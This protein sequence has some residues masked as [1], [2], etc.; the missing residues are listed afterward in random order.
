LPGIKTLPRMH[1]FWFDVD[2][3]IQTIP[4][5]S[6]KRM[7]TPL[8]P[9]NFQTRLANATTM[10]ES[11]TSPNAQW[12]HSQIML[13]TSRYLEVQQKENHMDPSQQACYQSESKQAAETRNHT[14][15]SGCGFRFLWAAVAQIRLLNECLGSV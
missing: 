7:Q 15:G 12:K 8:N 14:G 4:A 9:S 2:E 3:C 6:P 10:Q 13:S 11:I 1:C 5:Y